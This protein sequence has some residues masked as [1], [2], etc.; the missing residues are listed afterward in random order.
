[1][2]NIKWLSLFISVWIH[3]FLW[4]RKTAFLT[5]GVFLYLNKSAAGTGF[6]AFLLSQVT[7]SCVFSW[8][9]KAKPH[10]HNPS[11]YQVSVR[12]PAL[13]HIVVFA[14]KLSYRHL[15][16]WRRGLWKSQEES[17]PEWN[18]TSCYKVRPTDSQSK[19]SEQII[20]IDCTV[21]WNTQAWSCKARVLEVRAVQFCEHWAL[22]HLCSQIG[23]ADQGAIHGSMHTF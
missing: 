14:K 17:L 18:K 22:K 9:H 7:N 13:I 21:L 20:K 12:Y 23:Q 11:W 1:M 2:T 6:C 3:I 5:P 15:I 8:P 4:Y 10:L 19:I 16:I